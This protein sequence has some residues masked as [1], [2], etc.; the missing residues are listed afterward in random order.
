MNTS[1]FHFS[2]RAAHRVAPGVCLAGWIRCTSSKLDGSSSPPQSPGSIVSELSKPLLPLSFQTF[3]GYRTK[4]RVH[5]RL[6]YSL[7]L[8]DS[9]CLLLSLL[10]GRTQSLTHIRP[11]PHD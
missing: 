10:R 2:S 4:M 1:V 5:S 8:T 6:S 11:T 3:S 9:I 7:S